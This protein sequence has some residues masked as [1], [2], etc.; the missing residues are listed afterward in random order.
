MRYTLTHRYCPD[1]EARGASKRSDA[2]NIMI[3]SKD[4]DYRNKEINLEMW[5][6]I[7]P[8]SVPH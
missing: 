6:P 4:Y 7:E 8:I 3:Y 1:A 2:S 5:T